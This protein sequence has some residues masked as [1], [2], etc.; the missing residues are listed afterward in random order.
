MMPTNFEQFRTSVFDA[1]DALRGKI[2]AGEQRAYILP[3]VFIKC[4][5]EIL[6][7]DL[8]AVEEYARARTWIRKINSDVFLHE[9]IDVFS[10]DYCADEVG[11]RINLALEAIENAFSTQLGGVFQG[12]DFC[13]HR[14][15]DSRQRN[16]MLGS[17]L[18]S[19]RQ[20]SLCSIDEGQIGA[21]PSDFFTDAIAVLASSSKQ[22][23]ADFT[24]SEICNLV[25]KLVPIRRDE[26]IYDPVCGPG[27]FLVSAT[28]EA[29]RQDISLYR[30]YGQEKNGAAWAVAKMNLFLRGEDTVNI[31]HSD[32]LNSPQVNED[33]SLQCFNVVVSNPPWSMKN[34]GYES[35]QSDPYKRFTFGVPPKSNGDYAF[36]LSMLAVLNRTNG[37]MAVVVP[38]GSLFRSGNEGL[39]RRRL[40]EE[41][42]VDAV[43]ALPQK[44][45][46]HTGIA[47][48]ILILKNHKL[49][50]DVLFIDATN[51]YHTSRN[52]W[53]LS[54]EGIERIVNTYNA[55]LLTP[56]YSYI[57]N[58][59]D[60]GRNEFN[61]N[62][63][64]YVA[65][66]E[67]NEN[68]DLRALRLRR[69]EIK[70]DLDE[71]ELSIEELIRHCEQ[72][73]S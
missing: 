7:K 20:V 58:F 63:R 35:A 67:V 44:L 18:R 55:R 33:G 36:I 29:K 9:R 71:L 21:V 28:Q 60:L 3:I 2:S 65:K 24:P 73:N 22:E 54:D 30:L 31:T 72:N 46:L 48:N 11:F 62:V 59:D 39:I 51:E 68:V 5:L 13:N 52:R 15:G 69:Q 42:L 41:N 47:V 49:T 53:R 12:V 23:D 14:L 32:S 38:N 50:T 66:V 56:G 57:A 70:A 43:I 26:S 25:A 8:C 1:M 10:V 17:V 64:T 40:I 6:T 16:G 34:W 19:F 37:R 45:F 61:L 4:L 27:S